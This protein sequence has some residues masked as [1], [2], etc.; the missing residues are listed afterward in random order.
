MLVKRAFQEI[1]LAPESL[2]KIAALKEKRIL[3]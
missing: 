3:K 1:R 2:A